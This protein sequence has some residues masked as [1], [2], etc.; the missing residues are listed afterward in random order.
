[1]SLLAHHEGRGGA[2]HAPFGKRPTLEWQTVAPAPPKADA[3]ENASRFS[4]PRNGRQSNCGR[5]LGMEKDAPPAAI[6][7][8]SYFFS[9]ARNSSRRA[10]NFSGYS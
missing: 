10:L 1:M 2:G 5:A 6:P 8:G 3:Y 4:C 7:S 9:D